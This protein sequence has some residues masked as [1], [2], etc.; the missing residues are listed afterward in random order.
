MK[1]REAIEK[2]NR[3]H[4]NTMD[5]EDMYKWLSDLDHTIWD[6]VIMTKED[7]PM[8]VVIDEDNPPADPSKVEPTPKQFKPYVYDTDADTEL[9]IKAPYEEAY[10]AYLSA[11]CD[12]YEGDTAAYTNQMILYN[13]LYNEFAAAYT[14]AHMPKQRGYKVF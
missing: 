6:E 8:E 9:L 3:L 2:T 5:E 11:K 12:F 10:I 13:S 1:I 14:R 4:P 7:A